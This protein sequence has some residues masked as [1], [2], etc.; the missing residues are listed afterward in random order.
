MPTDIP[1]GWRQHRQE[2]GVVLHLPSNSIAASGLSM[3]HSPRWYRE[4]LWLLNSGSG[5]LG[6]LDGERFV[7]VA[8]GPGFVRGLAFHDRFALIGLSQLRSTSFGGLALEQRLA[9]DGQQAQ[10][11]LMVV[12]LDRGAVIHW[13]RFGNLVEELFDL[14]VIPAAR[15]PRAL[16]L[17]EDDIERLV[18]FPGS[19]G[20][21][22]TKPTVRRPGHTRAPVAGLP[23][24]EPGAHPRPGHR[25]VHPCRLSRARCLS[26]PERAGA[27]RDRRLL[28]GAAT[29]AACGSA[30]ACR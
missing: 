13:L 7:P 22:I 18:S 27:S 8:Y 19:N 4:R 20:L 15:R 9:A 28:A 6:Y 2:G 1:A 25:T 29:A 23:R 26:A 12:D 14:V 30:T 5:E 16:G 17:Q 10:C 24:P 3:P 11:G 21:V